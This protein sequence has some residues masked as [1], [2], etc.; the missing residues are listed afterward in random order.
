MNVQKKRY[1]RIEPHASVMVESMRD[2]RYSLQT[3]V[4]DVMDN[5]LAAG[6]TR[7]DLLT[8]TESENPAIGIKE[9]YRLMQSSCM[10]T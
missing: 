5:S 4:A 7:I 8:D 6:A 10:G 1:E 2:I 3:A 9:Q